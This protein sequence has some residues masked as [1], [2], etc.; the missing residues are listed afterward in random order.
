MSLPSL[1]GG[2][3][4]SVMYSQVILRHVW[5]LREC[6]FLALSWGKQP[7]PPKYPR[8]DFN[9]ISG[10][11][12]QMGARKACKVSPSDPLPLLLELLGWKEGRLTL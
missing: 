2:G 5:C 3:S 7:H 10:P 12:S 1:G 4:P 6:L 8:P 11:R 9:P